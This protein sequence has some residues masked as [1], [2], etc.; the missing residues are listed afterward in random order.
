MFADYVRI[1]SNLQRF[2]NK[3]F[4]MSLCLTLS[5]LSFK[6]FQ[7]ILSNQLLCID[8]A[9]HCLINDWHNLSITYVLL[10]IKYLSADLM[11]GDDR[12][13]SQA[14]TFSPSGLIVFYLPGFLTGL[15]AVTALIDSNRVG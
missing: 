11:S 13:M 3:L 5:V 12:L 15:P 6:S 2:A 9:W 14:T 1:N 4:D 10:Y 8:T 7:T